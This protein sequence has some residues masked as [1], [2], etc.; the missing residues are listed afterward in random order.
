[1]NPMRSIFAAG[2]VGDDVVV[3]VGVGEWVCR[4]S[5]PF[6]APWVVLFCILFP[7]LNYFCFSGPPMCPLDLAPVFGNGGRRMGYYLPFRL[8]PSSSSGSTDCDCIIHI[9]FVSG[10]FLKYIY[11]TMG[12]RRGY[13]VT[14]IIFSFL[15][16]RP[17]MPF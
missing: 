9:F 1:L 2:R 6:F 11:Y 15:F 5:R 12:R 7:V 3:G 16:S 8:M 4:C 14:R 13:V 10:D 17:G